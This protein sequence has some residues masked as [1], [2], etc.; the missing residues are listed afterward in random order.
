[1]LAPKPDD[2][3]RSISRAHVIEENPHKF[4]DHYMSTMVH[5]HTHKTL[6]VK[7]KKKDEEIA[8]HLIVICLQMVF[9]TK[10]FC[11]MFFTCALLVMWKSVPPSLLILSLHLL[12][13]PTF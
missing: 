11:L 8:Q 3:L 9:K 12:K 6:N 2:D 13:P 4:S 10:C 7:K 5:V 1:M